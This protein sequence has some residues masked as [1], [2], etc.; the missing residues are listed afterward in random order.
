MHTYE[1]PELLALPVVEGA[2]SYLAWMD[3]ELAP[4]DEAR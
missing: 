4:E 3:R 1:V 2:E